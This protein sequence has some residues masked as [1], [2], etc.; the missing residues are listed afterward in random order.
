MAGSV[1]TGVGTKTWEQTKSNW[2]SWAGVCWGRSSREEDKSSSQRRYSS[3]GKV[4]GD[5]RKCSDRGWDQALRINQVELGVLSRITLRKLVKRG[6]QEQ[7]PA[8]LLL[9]WKR[10]ILSHL[11]HHYTKT[12]VSASILYRHLWGRWRGLFSYLSTTVLI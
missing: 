12:F 9:C 10:H 6:E 4:K 8:S 1:V 2:K 7:Q 3:A 5:G 11:R